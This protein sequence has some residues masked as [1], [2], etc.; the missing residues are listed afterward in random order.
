MPSPQAL[1]LVIEIPVRCMGTDGI[2]FGSKVAFAFSHA[3]LLFFSH[4]HVRHFVLQKCVWDLRP[5]PITCYATEPCVTFELRVGLVECPSTCGLQSSTIELP[6]RCM[7]S[8]GIE[9]GPEVVH[10]HHS[11]SLTHALSD[12]R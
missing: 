3:V 12:V 11:S 8:D 9:Y 6:V 5:N 7:G 10:H 4:A 1:P 2:V